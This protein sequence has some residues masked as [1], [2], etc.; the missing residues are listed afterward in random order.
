MRRGGGPADRGLLL[1]FDRVFLI[2]FNSQIYLS[3]LLDRYIFALLV[4]IRRNPSSVAVRGCAK[5]AGT[6]LTLLLVLRRRSD[7]G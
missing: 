5:L 7:S 4:R 6:K 2:G 1:L 3:S